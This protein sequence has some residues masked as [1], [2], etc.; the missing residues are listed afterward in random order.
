[1]AEAQM[2]LQR[3]EQAMPDTE[4]GLE[5][6][7][8]IDRACAG[9]KEAAEQVKCRWGEIE[10]IDDPKIALSACVELREKAHFWQNKAAEA[11]LRIDRKLGET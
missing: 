4:G 6:L 2:E 9:V 10:N 5:F 8:E 1:M 11:K 7:E 3:H